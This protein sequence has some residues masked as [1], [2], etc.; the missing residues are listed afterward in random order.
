M[1]AVIKTIKNFKQSHKISVVVIDYLQLVN[2]ILKGETRERVIADMSRAF[3]QLAEEEDINIFAI[4]TFN[5]KVNDNKE[6]E[7]Y[8]LKESGALEYDANS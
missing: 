3:K 6:P 1:P 5:R 4:S 2:H 7:L 8:H